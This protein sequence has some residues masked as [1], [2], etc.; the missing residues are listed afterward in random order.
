[1]N[2]MMRRTAIFAVLWA[3]VA[4]VS[5]AGI[6]LEV[7][8]LLGTRTVRSAAIK[9]VYGNGTMFF[10]Y[11]AIHAWKGLFLGAGYEGGY[12]KTGAIG[13]YDE[14]ATLKVTGFEFFAGY[15]QAVGMISPFLRAGY[16]SYSFR[17][18]VNSAIHEANIIDS[19]KGT[20]VLAGGLKLSLS[21]SLSL[22]G[23]AKY[24]PLKVKPLDSEVDLGGMRYSAGLCLKF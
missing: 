16:G 10:P 17:Q 5:F 1:M 21:G 2:R 6:R 23:E 3:L 14:T 13:I 15:E 11:A 24:V 22:V 19:T 12:S 8:A 20:F 7:G 9:E 4:G 18:S